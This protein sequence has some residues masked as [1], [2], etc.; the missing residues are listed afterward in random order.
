[1]I[2]EKIMKK[3]TFPGKT[4]KLIICI[5]SQYINQGIKTLLSHHQ[6]LL[7]ESIR[8]L[9]IKFLFDKRIDE[10]FGQFLLQNSTIV[11]KTIN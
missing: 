8:L 1:M 6:K 9:Y 2:V 11:N 7:F 10:T 3:K 4:N 5:Y